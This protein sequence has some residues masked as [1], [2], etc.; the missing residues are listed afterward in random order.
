MAKAKKITKAR[1]G[2]KKAKK[3]TLPSFLQR[4]Q[5]VLIHPS[6]YFQSI[7]KENPTY[8]IWYYFVFTLL[9]AIPFA[10][11][12]LKNSPFSWVWFAPMVVLSVPLTMALLFVLAGISH[13]GLKLCKAQ[14]KYSDTLKVAAYASTPSLLWQIPY[15]LVMAW[16]APFSLAWKVLVLLS[17]G[18]IVYTIVLEVIGYSVLHKISKA[19]AFVGSIVVPVLFLLFL[20]LLIALLLFFIFKAFTN[21]Y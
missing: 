18:V 9:A 15:F 16:V 17:F 3:L 14:G 19:R 4:V 12:L 1:K 8:S 10:L 11:D 6:A 21:T 7:S 20:L 13:L 5:E 2:A